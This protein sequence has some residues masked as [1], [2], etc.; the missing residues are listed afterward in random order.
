MVVSEAA[1][2]L[3]RALLIAERPPWHSYCG[4]WTQWPC[5]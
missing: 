5:H 1:L 2:A 3:T 4:G